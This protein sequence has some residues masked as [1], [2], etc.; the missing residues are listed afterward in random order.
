MGL[1]DT[2]EAKLLGLL[3]PVLD[4][5]TKLWN[6]IKGFFTAIVEIIPKTVNLVKSTIDEVKGWK[7]FRSGV[8]ISGGIKHGVVSWPSFKQRIEDLFNEAI[9]AKDALVHLFTDGFKKS[10]LKPFEDAVEAAGELEELFSGLEKLGFKDFVARFGSKLKKAGGK[11][12]E[13]LAIAQAV[14]EELVKVVDELQTIVNLSRDLRSTIQTGE[15]LFLKQTN[16][17]KVVRLEDG[18]KIKVRLGNLHQ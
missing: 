18:G 17:R 6:T 15:G 5:L 7:E 14:A 12:F 9:A 2:I 4:P 11:I 10:T 3:K 16:R 1:I 13:V 8:G